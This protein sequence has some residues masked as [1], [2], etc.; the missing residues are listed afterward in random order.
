MKGNG[1]RRRIMRG[2]TT[3]KQD[4]ICGTLEFLLVMPKSNGKQLKDFNQS[5][6]MIKF[7][8]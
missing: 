1:E 8:C 6:D 3:G 4:H 7:A 2:E 5:Y